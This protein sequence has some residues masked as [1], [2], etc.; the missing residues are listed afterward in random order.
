VTASGRVDGASRRLFSNHAYIP[1][2]GPALGVN[3]SDFV[4]A[5]RATWCIQLSAESFLQHVHVV[6]TIFFL[7]CPVVDE[8]RNLIRLVEPLHGQ[9]RRRID[10]SSCV[11]LAGPRLQATSGVSL[12]FEFLT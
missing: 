10:S 12:T 4:D 3:V 11:R 9:L 7:A 8:L 2:V 5:E 1:N 6:P